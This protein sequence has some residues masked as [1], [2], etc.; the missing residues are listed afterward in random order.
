VASC[1][2]H[3]PAGDRAALAS[4]RLPLVL[5]AAIAGNTVSWDD[6]NQQWILDLRSNEYAPLTSSAG[7]R[8]SGGTRLRVLFT[9]RRLDSGLVEIGDESVIDTAQLPAIPGC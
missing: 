7:A 5:A 2:R 3:R 6:G 9:P 8:S 4:Y 1:D